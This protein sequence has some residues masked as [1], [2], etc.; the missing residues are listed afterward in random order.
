ME[1]AV[2]EAAIPQMHFEAGLR[3]DR[4]WTFFMHS[5]RAFTFGFVIMVAGPL[6]AR[7]WVNPRCIHVFKLANRRASAQ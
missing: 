5:I 2:F 1:Q 6:R 3:L 7:L 4:S